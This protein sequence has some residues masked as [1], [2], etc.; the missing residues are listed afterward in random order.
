[1]VVAAAVMGQDGYAAPGAWRGR[2][3]GGVGG[4]LLRGRGEDVS[5]LNS[6]TGQ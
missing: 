1:V 5:R 2:I 6:Y 4:V 3:V